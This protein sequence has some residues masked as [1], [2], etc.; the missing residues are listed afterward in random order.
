M[1]CKGGEE[2]CKFRLDEGRGEGPAPRSG[3]SLA[4]VAHLAPH[5]HVPEHDLQPV[6]EVVPDDN[7]GGAARGPALS[8]ADGLYAGGGSWEAGEEPG[9]GLAPRW[10]LEFG[11]AC[12][13]GTGR[14]VLTFGGVQAACP[15]AVLRVV[16]HK[17]VV[18]HGQHMSIHAHGRGHHHLR[19]EPR[20]AWLEPWREGGSQEGTVVD[21]QQLEAGGWMLEFRVSGMGTSFSTLRAELVEG[22]PAGSGDTPEAQSLAAQGN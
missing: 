4:R 15:A 8:R 12:G 11:W 9:Q 3:E 17:H 14:G 1:S 19:G 21:D 13:R 6:E 5:E 7:D 2:A 16:V 10:G 20:P 22:E 18:R